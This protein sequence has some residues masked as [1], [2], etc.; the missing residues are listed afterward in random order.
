MKQSQSFESFVLVLVA[1]LYA[2]KLACSA[3]LTASASPTLSISPGAER[4]SAVLPSF[5][6]L[7][8]GNDG[9]NGVADGHDQEAP[10]DTEVKLT[11][12]P[13]ASQM[14]SA[15]LLL[16]AV[17]S[18][19]GGTI[20][21][22]QSNTEFDDGNTYATVY[23]IS[24]GTLT[25]DDAVYTSVVQ[26]ENQNVATIQSGESDDTNLYSDTTG[27]SAGSQITEGGT[28]TADTT[29]ST[30]NVNGAQSGTVSHDYEGIS[31]FS[32]TSGN[33]SAE[34]THTSTTKLGNRELPYAYRKAGLHFSASPK[35]SSSKPV[36]FYINFPG[37]PRVLQKINF[38]P[39]ILF[40][41]VS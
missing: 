8:S 27:N 20:E 41:F 1:A 31:N 36:N 25:S 11:S 24:G 39:Y 6:D 34:L 10:A 23:H 19:S 40:P 30:M 9:S 35:D 21:Q 5:A 28:G 22:A 33:Q 32:I 15:D 12:R 3:Y 38:C 14:T 17:S 37:Y 13:E 4:I 16:G 29:H 7:H 26:S 18:T 2:P